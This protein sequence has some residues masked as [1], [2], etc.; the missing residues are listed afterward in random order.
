MEGRL[1]VLQSARLPLVPRFDEQDSDA[2][3][4]SGRD[5]GVEGVSNGEDLLGEEDGS[6]TGTGTGSKL[7]GLVVKELSHAQRR[8]VIMLKAKRE[9]LE[10]ER[11]RLTG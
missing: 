6:E 1:G 9:R 4:G 5:D 7:E 8:K 10:R 11:A 3:A 2:G